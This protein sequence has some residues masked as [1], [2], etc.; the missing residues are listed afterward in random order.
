M[1][2]RARGGRAARR[3]G[4]RRDP[5]RA[6]RRRPVPGPGHPGHRHRQWRRES[7]YGACQSGQA[8]GRAR[9]TQAERPRGAARPARLGGRSPDQPATR[10]SRTIGPRCRR[11]PRAIPV[12]DLRSRQRLRRKRTRRRPAG[13][14]QF[15]VLGPR[16]RRPHADARRPG[17]S[18]QP[19]RRDGRP[20]RCDGAGIRDRRRSA[21][22]HAHRRGFG[23]RCI[24][25]RDGHVDAVVGSARGTQRRC[26]P[27]SFRSNRLDEPAHGHLSDEG[28][29]PRP[30]DVPAGRQ[31][32]AGI[33]PHSQQ[34]R[35]RRRRPV[36]RYGRA[37]CERRG[38][39]RRI[40]R[41]L[42][43]P[44]AGRV[45]RD[46]REAGR[47]MVTHSVCRGGG[48]RSAGAG[49]LL[50]RRGRGAMAP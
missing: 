23:G 28:R 15:G 21:Q 9:P 44:H 31:V 26:D 50:H 37:A 4:R 7:L 43:R 6:A 25:A 8:L 12:A 16:R 30:A 17:L 49:Q 33:L 39:R 47:A 29:P 18:D 27:T 46:S 45:E 34:G 32:L 40:G 35:P 10:C 3:L 38:V 1:G 20:Q 14:R 5:D 13:L 11:R 36:R 2:L 42:R 19:A 48:R 22:T 41:D 24:A